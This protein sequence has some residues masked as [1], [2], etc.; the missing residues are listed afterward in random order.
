MNYKKLL[1]FSMMSLLIINGCACS[2]SSD[3]SG[4]NNLVLFYGEKDITGN[5]EFSNPGIIRINSQKQLVVSDDDGKST[6]Y[7]MLDM[8]GTPAVMM[9]C[10]NFEGNGSLFTLDANDNF[11]IYYEEPVIDPNT[12]SPKE[13]KRQ[14]LI[15]NNRGE[16]INKVEIGSVSNQDSQVNRVFDIAVDSAGNYYLAENKGIEFID[17]NGKTIKYIGTYPYCIALDSEDN[18]IYADDSAGV[19]GVKPF[20]EKMNVQT[21]KSIWKNEVA[22]GTIPKQLKVSS[23]EG[24]IIYMDDK[25]VKRYTAEGKPAEE[26]SVD[27]MSSD[28]LTMNL[29]LIS[30]NIDD[31]DNMYILAKDN[32]S[33]QNS[34]NVKYGLFKYTKTDKP[35]KV[36]K[37]TVLVLATAQ[38]NRFLET[39]I[40]MFQRENPNISIKIQEYNNA[41]QNP[42]DFE[43]YI[44]SL[45][46]E[47]MSGAGPDI[48]DVKNLPYKKYADKNSLVNLDELI[49]KDKEYDVN[50]YNTILIDLLKYKKQTYTIP[51]CFGIQSLVANKDEIGKIQAGLEDT[52]WTWQDF[53]SIGE[54][55]VK[56]I[57]GDGNIDQYAF[58]KMDEG[59][60]FSYLFA[61]CYN[62]FV[63]MENKKANFDSQDFVNLLNMCKQ[64]TDKNLSNPQVYDI[65][66]YPDASDR[67]QIVFVPQNIYNYMHYSYVKTMFNGKSQILSLPSQSKSGGTF[68]P[69]LLI[70]IN[71]NSKHVNEA[72]EF[73]K[74]LLSD[75]VQSQR[76]LGNTGFAIN[77]EALK[78]RFEED[79]KE[80]EDIISQNG[81][82]VVINDRKTDP[83][84]KE[85]VSAIE[86]LINDAQNCNNSEQQISS[87]INRELTPFF[88]GQKS[89]EEVSRIIQSKVETYLNE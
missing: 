36:E 50:K 16:Y 80:S 8:E 20:I 11:H 56:D 79:L 12:N 21:G 34:G 3:K 15:Y 53:I 4:K 10:D 75:E 41:S 40:N 78:K 33:L 44:K 39:A 69:K 25:G 48:I 31:S 70:S 76:E 55:A 62:Q 61:S 26:Y 14:I 47:M 51:L 35:K 29:D 5:S 19:P 1:L 7:V 27:F 38:S 13:F 85:D 63:D 73:L 49:S 2:L 28:I 64:F 18:L 30:L 22:P 66:S 42:E 88:T 45:S 37:K 89:A 57:N 46:T 82:S 60:L 77:K 84:A 67:G 23:K 43:K 86:K 52:K 32:A 68:V 54:K 83:L 87:I 58:I 24:Y 81:G 71:S 9:K 72:W 17:K 65:A 59:D 6:K 74:F